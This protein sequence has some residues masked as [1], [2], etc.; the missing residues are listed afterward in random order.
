MKP[1]TKVP[2][3]KNSMGQCYALRHILYQNTWQALVEEV[4]INGRKLAA[5]RGAFPLTQG[6]LA[7]K[8]KVSQSHISRLE[9]ESKPN[10]KLA[11]VGKLARALG[12][13]VSV[14]LAEGQAVTPVGD[15]SREFSLLNP[16]LRAYLKR[17]EHLP[18]EDQEMI[19]NV[20]GPIVEREDRERS[21]RKRKGQSRREDESHE[22][23]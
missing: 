17:I 20:I 10:A 14:L 16:R 12:V 7:I 18:P 11:T 3:S 5:L 15:R 4:R 23:S 1:S 2:I 13:P 21:V 22:Q 9:N 8:S 19:A 6:Q